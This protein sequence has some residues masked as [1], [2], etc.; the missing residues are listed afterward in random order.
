MTLLAA[1]LSRLC[2]RRASTSVSLLLLAISLLLA[3]ALLASSNSSSSISLTSLTITPTSGTVVFTDPWTSEAYA[4]AQNSFGGFDQDY[5]SGLGSKV[6]ANAWVQFA[7]GRALADPVNLVLKAQSV[8]NIPQEPI[9]FVAASSQGTSD[10]YNSTFMITGGTGQVNV[11]FDALFKYMQ[12]VMTNINGIN[13][14]SEVIFSLLVNGTPVL[15]Y[16]SPLAVGSN[17]SMQI[18]LTSQELKNSMTLDFDEDYTIYIEMDAESSGQSMP[19]PSTIALLIGGPALAFARRRI[20]A[21]R[22]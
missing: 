16:D 22:A 1:P 11:N 20:M 9:G 18:P 7:A 21:K 2:V 19:E 5:N 6:T 10:I 17:A 14:T 4:Q 12:S 8:V 15:F 3:P 13:A